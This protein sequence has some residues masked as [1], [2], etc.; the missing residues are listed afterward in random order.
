MKRPGLSR[1][2]NPESI[3]GPVLIIKTI[4]Y[5]INFFYQIQINN[6][7]TKLF[8]NATSVPDLP[9]PT[10]SCCFCNTTKGQSSDPRSNNDEDQQAF[11]Y[12]R[13]KKRPSKAV[14]QTTS[15]TGSATALHSGDFHIFNTI[16]P[17]IYNK[18]RWFAWPMGQTTHQPSVWCSNYYFFFHNFLQNSLQKSFQ[19][20][21]FIFLWIY[22]N[23]NKE[24]WV[25]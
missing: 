25:P 10:S 23:K 18:I 22:K 4:E 8:W 24:F 9:R 17:S 5:H 7:K 13:N 6:L 3:K 1:I 11:F 14:T 21:F 20:F 15:S 19:L 12:H 2:Y 16:Y